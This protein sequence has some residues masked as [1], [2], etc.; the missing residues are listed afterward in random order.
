ME[1]QEPKETP[2]AA[3]TMRL[4]DQCSR[5]PKDALKKITGGRLNGMTDIKPQWRVK[6]LTE[7]FGPC[8]EGWTYRR[9][10][11]DFREGSDGQIV[12]FVDIE[13]AYKTADGKWSEPIPG[14]G[15]SMYIAK[16]KSGLFT[17][18]EAIKMATTDAISVAAKM[19]GVG[20]EIYEG[21]FDGTKYR[22]ETPPKPAAQPAPVD[23]GKHTLIDQSAEK[24]AWKAAAERLSHTLEG[25]GLTTKESRLDWVKR[26]GWD[27]LAK[28]TD[29]NVSDLDALLLTAQAEAD[30]MAHAATEPLPF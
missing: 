8:G 21:H 9:T 15:G 18:D 23:T 7:M 24:A 13:L 20:S 6:V 25:L 14:T 17:S 27:D 4:W 10:N 1:P 5:P 22:D 19:L 29:L 11:L 30:A 2:A 12:V 3:D 16:E 28:I 26:N